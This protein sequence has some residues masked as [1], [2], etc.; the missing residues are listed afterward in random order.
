[1]YVFHPVLLD[2]ALQVLMTAFPEVARKEPYLPV[3]LERLRVHRHTG[4]VGLG[5]RPSAP[6]ER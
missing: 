3:G 6:S 1:M 2:A 4:D 5:A